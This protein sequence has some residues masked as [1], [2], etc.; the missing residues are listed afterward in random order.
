MNNFKNKIKKISN[1]REHKVTN[2]YGVKDYYIYYKQNRPRES[3]YVITDSDYRKIIR[4]TNERLGKKLIELGDI[5]FPLDM[6]N[7]RIYKKTYLPKFV[8]GELVYNA[9]INWDKTLEL[10]KEDNES[11]ISKTLVR[12]DPGDVY[13]IKYKN[14]YCKFTNKEFFNFNVTRAI[15]FLLKEAIDKNS[16]IPHFKTKS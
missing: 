4:L 2:S 5:K 12:V 9:P 8:D 3:K 1:N 10:W 16:I 7:L 14:I 13:S 11:R 6:G 15:K